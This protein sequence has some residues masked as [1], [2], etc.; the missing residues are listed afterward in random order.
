MVSN[1]SM[2]KEN[3]T[4]NKPKNWPLKLLVYHFLAF[5][6]RSSRESLI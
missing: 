6:L 5:W 3:V 4:K 2:I 1:T